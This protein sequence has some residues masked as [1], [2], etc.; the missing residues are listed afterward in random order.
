M[1]DKIICEN[2]YYVEGL[3]YNFLSVSQ[4][5][6]TVCKVEFGNRKVKI[7]DA[8]GELIGNGDQ[9]RGNLFYLD[10]N[11]VTC[12]VLQFDDVW[13][14]HKRLCHVNFDNLVGISKM[15]RVRGLPK[16]KN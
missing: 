1:I 15:K 11:D 13:L 4:L 12:L 10:M 14:W 8:N 5:N 2:A 6:S 9:T 3:N 16:L 7:Y